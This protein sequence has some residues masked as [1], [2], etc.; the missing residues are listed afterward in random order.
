M[1]YSLLRTDGPPKALDLPDIL[2]DN[3]VRFSFA[4]QVCLQV[5]YTSGLTQTDLYSHKS[6]LEE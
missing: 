6:S 5:C 4:Y 3:L 2:G 1:L